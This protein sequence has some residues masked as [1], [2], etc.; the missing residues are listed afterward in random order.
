MRAAQ[1]ESAEQRA[2]YGHGTPEWAAGKAVLV[3]LARLDVHHG[4]DTQV[5]LRGRVHAKRNMSS[6][7]AFVILRQQL[8]TIQCVV[9]ERASEVSLH[10]V[11]WIERI[12]GE[13]KL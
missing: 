7:L 4:A 11:R 13:L 8:D 12:P 3:D 2:R 5:T 1:V 10:M 6:H 9:N